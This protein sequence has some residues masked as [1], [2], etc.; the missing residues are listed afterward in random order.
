MVKIGIIGVGYFGEI[1]LKN[2]LN[3]SEKFN[4]IGIYDINKERASEISKKYKIDQFDSLNSLIKN[5][6]AVNITC[7]TN[8]HF[9]VIKE[10]IKNNKHIFI[11]KPLSENLE[12]SKEILKLSKSYKPIIQIGF[13]ERFNDVFLNLTKFNFSIKEIYAI[14]TGMLS[15]RNKSSCIIQDM[16]IHDLDIINYLIQSSIKNIS[17]NKKST[18]D[19]VMCQIKFN[20]NC[21][22]NIET[23]RSEKICKDKSERKILI[24]TNS[25]KK[26]TL[27]FL[28]KKICINKKEGKEIKKTN[29]LSNELIYFYECIS[30]KKINKLSIE[31][32]YSVELISHQIKKQ[33]NEIL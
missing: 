24:K 9:E 17:I 10:C 2:L 31:S 32:A 29:A 33:L 18:K 27:D 25:N 15:E 6:E 11:E 1:H 26:I 14:R 3:L 21:I 28:N 8:S 12:N 20:N 23:E 19:K 7:A 22:A 16:M 5:C 13:I 30:N 4:V